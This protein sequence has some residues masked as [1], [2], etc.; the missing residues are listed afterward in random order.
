[1]NIAV[2]AAVSAVPIPV[3]KE[4]L[5]AAGAGHLVQRTFSFMQSGGMNRPPRTAADIAAEFPL[6]PGALLI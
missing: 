1:L 2:V 6:A 5:A 3:G 4:L